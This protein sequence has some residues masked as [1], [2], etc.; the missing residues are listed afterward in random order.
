MFFS[1]STTRIV[2]AISAVYITPPKSPTQRVLESMPVVDGERAQARFREMLGEARPPTGGVPLD[3]IVREAAPLL[4][5]LRELPPEERAQGD[6]ESFSFRECTLLGRRLALLDLTPT[7]AVQVVQVALR[8]ADDGDDLPAR[9]FAERMAAAAIEGFVLG[10][11]EHVLAEHEARAARYL[12]P[13]RIDGRTFALLVAGVHEPETLSEQVDALGRAML[14]VDADL[15]IVDLSRL[16][17]PTRDRAAAIFSADEVVRLLGGT[18][19]FCGVDRRWRSAMQD[20]H[21]TVEHLQMCKDFAEALAAAR[22]ALDTENPRRSRWR[23]LLSAFR[24]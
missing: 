12:S 5:L 11:E 18:C 1:S 14:D 17:E 20:A 8:A 23:G 19:L 15:A 3:D 13:I 10:R 24:R 9:R 4:P 16:G 7:A 22:S 6:Y 21:I 2:A